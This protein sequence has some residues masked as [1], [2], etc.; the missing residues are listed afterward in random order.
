MVA[1]GSAGHSGFWG[2]D[3]DDHTD[4]QKTKAW[5]VTLQS[6]QAIRA[7]DKT[8]REREKAKQREAVA[9]SDI[10][11]VREYLTKKLPDGDTTAGISK[12]SWVPYKRAEKALVALENDGVVEECEV[13]KRDRKSG[14]PGWKLVET[15]AA[16]TP[17]VEAA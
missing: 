9:M 12:G 5:S 1:G 15:D 10:T 2:L 17:E 14:R 7:E 3:I 11:A 16:A 4:D 8:A 6:I 13:T